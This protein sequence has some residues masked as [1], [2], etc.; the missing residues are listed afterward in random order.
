V[1]VYVYTRCLIFHNVFFGPLY[2]PFDIY[3]QVYPFPSF[4]KKG[5][6]CF[7]LGHVL[8]ETHTHILT[9]ERVG[10]RLLLVREIERQ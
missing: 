4:V 7:V 9:F 8:K 1:S 6:L 3:C 10:E 5:I 2:I